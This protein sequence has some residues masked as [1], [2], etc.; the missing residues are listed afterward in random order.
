[1]EPVGSAHM[2]INKVLMILHVC[3][4]SY[5]CV[6]VCVRMCSEQSK[7]THPAAR[8]PLPSTSLYVC[9]QLN[10]SGETT[11]GKNKLCVCV[12][13][14][15]PVCACVCVCVC[16]SLSLSLFCPNLLGSRKSPVCLTSGLIPQ[17]HRSLTWM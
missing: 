6:C 9:Q 10:T 7:H 13:T 8:R 5:V 12:C 14:C 17:P 1:M 16:V 4:C 2:K 11:A 15:V 3:V